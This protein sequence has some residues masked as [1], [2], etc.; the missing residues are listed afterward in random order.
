MSEEAVHDALKAGFKYN[1]LF[2]SENLLE[3]IFGTRNKEEAMNKFT[4][5]E[6]ASLE[7]KY[8]G[9]GKVGLV[10]PSY[11]W[12]WFLETDD[13]LISKMSF[14]K[15][16]DWFKAVQFVDSSLPPME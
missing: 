7:A 4:T 13:G 11:S 2:K 15:E 5:E 12:S 1:S 16:F 9:M 3:K 10:K 14:E 6:L 8:K